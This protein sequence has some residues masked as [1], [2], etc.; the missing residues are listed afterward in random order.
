MVETMQYIG[1][2]YFIPCVD[3][4]PDDLFFTLGT[5]FRLVL[6][7]RWMYD[8]IVVNNS[9]AH[10]WMIAILSYMVRVIIWR[11]DLGM[12][13]FG[14]LGEITQQSTTTHVTT[15][16]HTANWSNQCFSNI[17]GPYNK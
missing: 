3:L 9:L 6:H 13:G 1:T 12:Y 8:S 7:I 10:D 16:K 15:M 5:C 2:M 17:H 14:L 11:L 4:D